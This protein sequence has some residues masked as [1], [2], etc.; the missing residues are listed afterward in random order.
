[1]LQNQKLNLIFFSHLS[2]LILL[3]YENISFPHLYSLS[4]ET[5]K[6]SRSNLVLFLCDDQGISKV[7][8]NGRNISFVI[9]NSLPL[10]HQSNYVSKT[11]P[12][13]NIYSK[14]R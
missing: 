1:M 5:K 9:L 3:G 10:K 2:K 6:N 7:Q 14:T 8:E 11:N 4:Y 13:G 12:K